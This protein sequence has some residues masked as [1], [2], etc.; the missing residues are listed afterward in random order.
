V[1][2]GRWERS[3][4][5]LSVLCGH[6]RHRSATPGTAATPPMLLERTGTG[7]RRACH[8]ASYEP[9][10]TAPSN[11]PA[12][13]GRT[14]NLY[15][16]TPKAAPVRAQDAPRH[17]NRSKIRQDGR[18]LHGTTRHASTHRR[19][20]R[21][22]C[23]LLPPWPIKGEAVPQPQGTRRR[24]AIT[25]TLPAFATILALASINTSGT[26]RPGLLST[27]LVAPLYEHHGAKQYSA[28]STPLLDVRPRLKPGENPVSLVASTDP[29]RGRSQRSLLLSVGTTF[30]TD[31]SIGFFRDRDRKTKHG[32]KSRYKKYSMLGLHFST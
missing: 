29:S 19:I 24:I 18:Q 10:L 21:H 14:A 3:S 13:G 1:T 6:P 20:V 15:T 9:P 4:P 25:H 7:R 23:K 31:K 22:A 5:S 2:W 32:Q 26:W 17:P 28:P 8:C 11:R 16:T 30:R 27:T 12:G